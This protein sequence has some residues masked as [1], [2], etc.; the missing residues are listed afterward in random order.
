MGIISAI[1]KYTFYSTVCVGAFGVFV[2]NRNKPKRSDLEARLTPV[3]SVINKVVSTSFGLK[4]FDII[5]AD[6]AKY[7]N[8]FYL[9]I[10]NQWIDLKDLKKLTE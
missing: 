6:V 5:F 2:L 4:Y 9:G 8:H 7:G 1:I 10:C 3:Q